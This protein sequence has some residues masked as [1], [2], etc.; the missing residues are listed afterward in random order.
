MRERCKTFRGIFFF[1]FFFYLFENRFLEHK[2]LVGIGA[3]SYTFR[4][5]PSI[6]TIFRLFTNRLASGRR[7]ISGIII[8][9]QLCE[10]SPYAPLAISTPTAR[11]SITSYYY[12][13]Y[14]EIRNI[15]AAYSVGGHVV[16]KCDLCN[17]RKFTIDD[18]VILY[19][20]T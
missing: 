12:I 5:R 17:I 6:S 16:L 20:G 9:G 14:F 10:H 3:A 19:I 15:P 11:E 4:T 7:F 1:M 18:N 13:I 2:K 8:P